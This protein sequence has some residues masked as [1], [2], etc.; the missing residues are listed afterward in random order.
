MTR[1]KSNREELEK[2]AKEMR[3]ILGRVER[4]LKQ[5]PEPKPDTRM[6]QAKEI[7]AHL[8][9]EAGTRFRSASAKQ[10]ICQRLE[11]G[12]SVYEL[13][14]MISHKVKEWGGSEK[15]RKYLRPA[16]LFCSSKC[17]GYVADALHH[18]KRSVRK[19]A[20]PKVNMEDAF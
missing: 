4:I 9:S 18:S 19:K 13:K 20:V 12:A 2:V 11:E 5:A 14:V 10:S 16:T 17:E 15:M 8:N 7:L 6:P 3:T 1:R